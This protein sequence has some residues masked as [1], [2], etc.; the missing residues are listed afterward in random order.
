MKRRRVLVLGTDFTDVLVS[1]VFDYIKTSTKWQV[2][3]SSLQGMDPTGAVRW[4]KPDGV[5]VRAPEP[6]MLDEIRAIVPSTVAISPDVVPDNCLSIGIDDHEIGRL[7]AEHL[8]AYGHR[9]FGFYGWETYWS[10]DRLGGFTEVLE[11]AGHECHVLRTRR[12][13]LPTVRTLDARSGSSL[14]TKWLSELPRPMG[15]LLNHDIAAYNLFDACEGLGLNIPDDIAIVSVDNHERHCLSMQPSLTSIDTN[16]TQVGYRAAQ[17]LDQLMSNGD[18]SLPHVVVPPQG[19]VVRQSTDRHTFEDEEVNRALHYIHA[20]ADEAISV[21][22]VL[23]QVRISRS[24]LEA[25]FRKY[26]GHTPGAEIR[27][28]RLEQARKL[29]LDTNMSLIEIGV[30]CGFSSISYLSQAFKRAYGI[31]PR[32]YRLEHKRR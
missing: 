14:A 12:G 10:H 4:H 1:G 32:A 8:L 28:V 18:A 31:S 9:H 23:E 20:N 16:L 21:E 5:L 26:L 15:M 30:R 25:R 13:S 6:D 29:L 19:V 17:M 7:A 24:S 22:D 2:Q 3:T 27:R 11:Q